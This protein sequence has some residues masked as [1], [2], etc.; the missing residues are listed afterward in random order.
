MSGVI[1]VCR[2]DNNVLWLLDPFVTSVQSVWSQEIM[3]KVSAGGLTAVCRSE[4]M[5]SE[6][7]KGFKP[8]SRDWAVPGGKM[9]GFDL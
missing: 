8:Q 7:S 5:K 4:L 2:R 3:I 1:I 9:D 6:L